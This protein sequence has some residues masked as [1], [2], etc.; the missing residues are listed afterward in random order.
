MKNKAGALYRWRYTLVTAGAALVIL[1]LMYAMLGI[2]PFGGRS[3]LTGDLNGIYLPYFSN[4]RSAFLGETGFSYSFNKALGGELA[5]AFAYYYSSPF[6]LLY[7]LAR[8][9]A[10]PLVT[11]LVFALKVTLACCFF[12]LYARRRFPALGWMAVALG[13]GYGFMSYSFAYAQNIMWLDMVMVLPLVCHG[14]EL[15]LDGKRPFIYIL[16]LA[17]AVY[18]NFY[19]AF[20]LC[21]FMVLYFLYG[22]FTRPLWNKAGARVAGV[23]AVSS[24]LGAGASAAVLLPGLADS[25]ASKGSL[26]S[27]RFTWERLFDLSLL[28][29]QEVW[30]AFQW[31][32][33]ETGRPL[34]Y[35]GALAMVLALCFFLRRGIPLREK[36]LA[37]GILAVL[38][39][40]FWIRGLD[41]IWHGFKTPVWFPF[42]YSFVFCFF[43]CFLGARAAAAGPAARW[44]LPVAGGALAAFYGLLLLNARSVSH[45]KIALTLALALVFCALLALAA[46]KLTIKGK[47]PWIPLVICLTAAELALNGWYILGRFELYE[48]ERYGGFIEAGGET[49]AA[50]SQAHGAPDKRLLQFRTE[51]DF[52]YTLNDSMLLGYKGMSHFSSTQNDNS[53]KMMYNLGWRGYAY[54]GYGST[55]FADSV[56]GLR[57]LAE[58]G[59]KPLPAHWAP[60]EAL[61]GATPYPVYQNSYALPIAFVI[62]ETGRQAGWESDIIA[63]QNNLYQ[64]LSGEGGPLLLPA[65]AVRRN[66]R[67]DAQPNLAGE[68]R[69]GDSYT[70]TAGE[71]GWYYAYALPENGTLYHLYTSVDGSYAGVYFS[72]DHRGIIQLG[73]LEAGESRTL[74]WDQ[75][76]SI[77]LEQFS[78]CYI[79]RQAM[80]RLT[81]AAWA[82]SGDIAVYDGHIVGTAYAGEGEMLFTSVPYSPNWRGTV[83]G[84]PAEVTDVM[85]GF[86]ALPLEEGENT[87]DIRYHTPLSTAGLA[88]SLASIALV[89]V[90]WLWDRR[91]RGMPSRQNAS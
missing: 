7:V 83:N 85:G 49:M 51:K 77:R 6:N 44:V 5:G 62:G 91:R 17:Y 12:Q 14:A 57:Y 24:I 1:G 87:V 48:V 64:V 37:A 40:S 78:A 66:M 86:M 19:I 42:R 71:P 33:V 9:A 54:Y 72:A 11:S 90:W 84:K 67:G 23:F 18:A 21:L 8:P 63:F 88:A 20:M 27:Y 82:Q 69:P 45:S 22:F 25:L 4:L 56:L 74:A 59:S 81:E 38:V 52:F 58:D 55:V 36:L 32:N 79:S 73:W 10:Y 75:A 50:I 89:C 29:E 31:S 68:V 46:K 39:L 16:S 70:I 47:S 65:M 43:L 61:A 76:D 26:S 41:L 28:P 34:L 13:L 15:V 2:T 80:Q 60:D 35:C 53:D 3:L 30:G